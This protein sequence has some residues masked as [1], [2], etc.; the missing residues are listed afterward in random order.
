MSTRVGVL[1]HHGVKGMKWG[2][3]RAREG[4]VNATPKARKAAKEAVIADQKKHA[5]TDSKTVNRHVEKASAHG[6]SAL[7]NKQ[8]EEVNKRLNL[9]QNFSRLTADSKQKGEGRKFIENQLKQQGGQALQKHGQ[10][11][12][13]KLLAKKAAKAAVVAAVL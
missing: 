12:I 3:R 11:Q 8:L 5:S 1:E 7:T 9:E 6:T 10:A 13:A 2:V 4:V